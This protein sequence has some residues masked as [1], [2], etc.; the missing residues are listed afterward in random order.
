M[1]ARAADGSMRD[2]L[3]PHRPGA[4]D[5]RRRTSR[6]NACATRSVSCPRTNSSRCSTSSPSAAPATCSR[7]SARLAD[8]G[9][10]FGGF[11]T[12]FADMLRAQLAVVLGGDV[13]GRLASARARRSR[14][15]ASAFA[16]GDL[17][18]MLQCDRASSSRASGRAAS[19][20]CCSRRCSF[21]SRCSI[22]RSTLEDVLRGIGGDGR[23]RRRAPREP[24]P[25]RYEAGR[26][27]AAARRPC[28]R[29]AVQRRAAPAAPTHRADARRP[30]ARRRRRRRPRV[31][32]RAER[33]TLSALAGRWDDARRPLRAGRRT[34]LAT[35]ALE[36]RRRRGHRERRLTIELDEPTTSTRRRSKR[37]ATR[38]PRGAPRVVRRRRR[39]RRTRRA[40]HRAPSARNRRAT[41]ARPTKRVAVDGGRSIALR[42]DSTASSDLGE[43]GASAERARPG[44]CAA[45]DRLR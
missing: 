43:D 10:D 2:A 18:R 17:L 5:G 44:T 32:D 39:R 45:I 22:A 40:I 30:P 37:R 4:V 11:L 6:P 12:G 25:R 35:A 38:S 8:A 14:R 21:A 33:S 13:A 9:I 19:S 31:R 29:G 24:P 3:S 16:A 28:R 26:A 27:D 20:S 41:R 42:S 36:H 34:V 1:I 15:D 23:S 7:R